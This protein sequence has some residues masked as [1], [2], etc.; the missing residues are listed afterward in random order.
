MVQLGKL[1][2]KTMATQTTFANE[3]IKFQYKPGALRQ[4]YYDLV[5]EG[6]ELG[7]TDKI[8]EAV[9]MVLVDWE[10][11]IEV[12]DLEA[13]GYYDLQNGDGKPKYKKP[14]E[15]TIPLP[16]TPDALQAADIPVPLFGRINDE[17]RDDASSGG[18]GTKK[19]R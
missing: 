13:A 18:K 7:N 12:A 19:G 2:E 5:Q 8:Y 17:I 6:L 4:E 16:I 3:I 10:L 1:K 9:C 14:E 15:K 11:E